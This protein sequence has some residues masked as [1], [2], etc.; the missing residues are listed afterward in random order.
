MLETYIT[1]VSYTLASVIAVV[2][3]DTLTQKIVIPF[4]NSVLSNQKSIVA[5]VVGTFLFIVYCLI[6]VSIIAYLLN[7]EII[8]KNN[9]DVLAF[10][11]FL[12]L[13]SFLASKYGWM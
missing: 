2:F 5:A 12:I 6:A 4:I 8:N 10:I 3:G 9:V 13:M 1:E 11:S 7:S